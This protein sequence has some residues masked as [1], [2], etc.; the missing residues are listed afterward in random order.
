MSLTARLDKVQAA[1]KSKR[2]LHI[3]YLK[4]FAADGKGASVTEAVNFLQRL[5]KTRDDLQHKSGQE[6]QRW[7]DECAQHEGFAT[8]RS[9]LFEGNEKLEELSNSVLSRMYNNLQRINFRRDAEHVWPIV[10]ERIVIGKMANTK[11]LLGVWSVAPK[12]VLPVIDKQL[13]G[14]VRDE[15]TTSWQLLSAISRASEWPQSKAAASCAKVLSER[16]VDLSSGDLALIVGQLGGG[17]SEQEVPS[18]LLDFM[19]QAK[20]ELVKR[21]GELESVQLCGMFGAIENCE[22]AL[23]TGVVRKQLLAKNDLKA[24]QVLD[25]LRFLDRATEKQ[26]ERALQGKLVKQL[27]AL[28]IKGVPEPQLVANVARH[29]DVLASSRGACQSLLNTAVKLRDDLYPVVLWRLFVRAG[30][31]ELMSRHPMLQ[32]RMERIG[33]ILETHGVQK[34]KL[35]LK[36]MFGVAKAMRQNNVKLTRCAKQMAKHFVEVLRRAEEDARRK[37]E[38]STAAPIGEPATELKAEASAAAPID[39]PATELKVEGS[40]AAPIEEPATELKADAGSADAVGEELLDKLKAEDSTA[41]ISV[42]SAEEVKAGSAQASSGVMSLLPEVQRL[43]VLFWAELH[44]L[45][46]E[47]HSLSLAATAICGPGGDC[48]IEAMSLAEC[49]SQLATAGLSEA[50][51]GLASHLTARLPELHLQDLF[52]V[53]NLAVSEGTKSA[54][55]AEVTRRL[56]PQDDGSSP[57]RI[58]APQTGADFDRL[59]SLVSTMNSWSCPQPAA[60]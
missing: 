5:R 32:A 60:E 51:E 31:A 3:D 35:T 14:A 41:S 20:A 56:S 28:L 10:S 59:V 37:A 40:A 12:E 34:Q 57:Q 21:G 38:G 17:R 8:L 1:A 4:A 39:E 54:L 23:W 22:D 50:S 53:T 46:I 6:R 26:D 11:E 2:L 9:R 18:A 29:L 58:C 24:Q 7:A 55:A 33:E 27:Q 48:R 45:G 16:L 47:E 15:K 49:A 43:L 13:S 42:E 44:G 52:Q 30:N 36:E 19:R 25:A